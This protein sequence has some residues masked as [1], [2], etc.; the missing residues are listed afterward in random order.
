M[1]LSCN[2]LAEKTRMFEIAPQRLGQ[3]YQGG[4]GNQDMDEGQIGARSAPRRSGELGWGL[5]LLMWF[6]GDVVVATLAWFLVSLLL[7]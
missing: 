2:Q 1:C 4:A 3:T 5:L 7:K 6:A